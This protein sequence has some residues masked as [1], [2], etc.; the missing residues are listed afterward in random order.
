ME[1]KP[2][3]DTLS[4]SAQIAVEDIQQLHADG[5]KTLICNRPDGEDQ[6][7]PEVEQIKKIAEEKGLIFYFM[8]VVSGQVTLAQGEQ[9]AQALA[10][11]PKPIH[12]YCRSGMRCTILWG[13]SQLKAGV[14]KNTI[15]EQAGKAGYDLSKLF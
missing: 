8:P 3:S 13:M 9:F 11:A 7:Q 15:I 6:G 12:A 10:E 1:R 4:V 5:V 14:D 2:L